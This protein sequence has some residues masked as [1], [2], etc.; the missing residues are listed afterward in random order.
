VLLRLWIKL[1]LVTCSCLDF[2]VSS[3][4]SSVVSLQTDDL[5]VHSFTKLFGMFVV[6]SVLSPLRLCL[7]VFVI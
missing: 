4:R 5:V 7:I 3:D 2:V 6:N 1:C